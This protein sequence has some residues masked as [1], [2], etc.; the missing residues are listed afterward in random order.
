[1]NEMVDR[2]AKAI[3]EAADEAA[4]M[5]GEYC[6][7][8]MAE[9]AAIAAIKAMRKPTEKITPEMIDA[10]LEKMWDYDDYIFEDVRRKAVVNIFV[11]MIDAALKDQAGR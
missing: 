1:M 3:L 4:Q 8:A 7:P 11:A 2:V 10:G 9:A 5:E 6:S